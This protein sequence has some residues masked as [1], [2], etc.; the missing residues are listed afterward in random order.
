MNFLKFYLRS[1]HF[2]MALGEVGRAARCS[3]ESAATG[4]G[5]TAGPGCQRRP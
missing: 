1:E 4:S 5:V 2:G 3:P